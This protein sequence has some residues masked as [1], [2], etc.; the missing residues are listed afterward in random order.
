LIAASAAAL[1]AA[2]AA[3]LIAASAAGLAL[4]GFPARQNPLRRA[5]SVQVFRHA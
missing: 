1:I 2:S 5:A 4:L 3:A